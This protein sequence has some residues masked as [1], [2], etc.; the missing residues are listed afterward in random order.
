[1]TFPMIEKA[2]S[3][4]RV[5][6]NLRHLYALMLAGEVK[7]LAEAAKGLVGPAVEALEEIDYHREGAGQ[8]DC[9]HAPCRHDAL[10]FLEQRDA[11][12]A[13]WE[14]L[15][16]ARASCCDEM[17]QALTMVATMLGRNDLT[18]ELRREVI[19]V[20]WNALGKEG[21]PP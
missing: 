19:V 21:T 15:E 13:K 7:D 6:A 10:L 1:M 9:S 8:C 11:W 16:I 12:K 14:K 20:I 17:E 2:H 3:L 18:P 5:I 4:P